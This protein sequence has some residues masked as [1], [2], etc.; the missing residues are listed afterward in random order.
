M[1]LKQNVYQ[2]IFVYLNKDGEIDGVIGGGNE[3]KMWINKKQEKDEVKYCRSQLL[4]AF[5]KVK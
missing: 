3:N 2:P 5:G 1:F 4:K